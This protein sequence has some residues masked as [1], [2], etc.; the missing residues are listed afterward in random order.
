VCQALA[1]Q[2]R[3][4]KIDFLST[5]SGG[6]YFGAC[7][8]R[9]FTR[10]EVKG[11]GDVQAILSPTQADA[12]A[13]GSVAPPDLGGGRVLRWLRENGR[14]LSPNGAGDLPLGLAVIFRN[15]LALHL[16]LLSFVLMLFLA[17]QCLRIALTLT[18]RRT[19]LVG[20]R[21]GL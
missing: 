9:L 12:A 15:W 7:L 21:P 2:D 20:R 13:S 19:G 3:L 18:R 5:V 6:G 16:V 14:H 1:K 17:A 8:G 10:A 4:G 11:V